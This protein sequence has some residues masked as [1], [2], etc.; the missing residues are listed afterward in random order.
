MSATVHSTLPHGAKPQP[1]GLGQLSRAEMTALLNNGYKLTPATLAVKI[2]DGKWIPAPHL[3]YLSTAVTTAIMKGGQFIIVTMPPRHGKSEFLSV[4]VPIWFLEH[5]P[6]QR[7]ILTSYGADLATEFA[8]KVRDTF[9]NP[10]LEHLLNTRL[11]RDKMQLA[12]FKT[13]E[14]GGMISIGIGGAITGKGADLLLVDDY[15]K[16]AEE[17]LSESQK[18]KAWEWLLSTALTRVEPGGSVIMLATRWDT[19]DLIGMVLRKFDELQEAGFEPPTIINLPALARPNDPLGR[20][21]GEALWPERY[22]EKA[23][24]RLKALLGTYWWEG[25]YQQDPPSSMS[26]LNLGD[27]LKLIAKEELPHYKEL[28]AVRAWDMAATPEEIAQANDADYTVGMLMLYHKETD[29]VFITEAVRKRLS[30]MATHHLMHA[31]AEIDGP[32]VKIW[33]EQ[34]PGSAGK[35]TIEYIQSDVLPEYDVEGEKSTGPVEVRCQPFLAKV[36]AGDVYVVEGEYLEPF[37]E[38]LNNFPEGDH[39]DTV[40]AASLGYRKL[41][42]GRFGGLTWGRNRESRKPTNSGRRAP[43]KR[44]GRLTW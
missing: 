6:T 12:N 35:W 43:Y 9:Q 16:N 34:E 36:E 18:K 31:T 4:N 26:G 38:E 41:A 33:V 30:P 14:G 10:D 44:R 24:R 15:V 27:K 28:K 25:L 42:K 5:F 2:T 39:D 22:D 23:L 32:G 21:E 19:K 37:R 3:L 13:T 40:V 8:L 7:I 1:S 29:R 17:A 11:R 20:K